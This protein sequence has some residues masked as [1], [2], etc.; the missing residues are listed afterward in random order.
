M[1][2]ANLLD[3]NLSG[4]HLKAKQ[5][6]WGNVWW[7][8]STSLFGFFFFF[9][10]VLSYQTSKV[11]QSHG[12]A[13]PAS[14]T[15]FFFSLLFLWLL[16]K[17]FK[18]NYCRPVGFVMT[19]QTLCC[20]AFSTFSTTEFALNVKQTLEV[21]GHSSPSETY[22]NFQVNISH[23]FKKPQQQ[24]GQKLMEKRSNVHL[25]PQKRENTFVISQKEL[26]TTNLGRCREASS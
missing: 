1:I 19:V 13:A 20:V 8:L 11:V 10:S 26:K 6:R 9:P 16:A 17:I 5:K 24:F 15:N 7:V 18:G 3:F 14:S 23:Y 2:L 4:C 25:N 21:N 12:P 22:C